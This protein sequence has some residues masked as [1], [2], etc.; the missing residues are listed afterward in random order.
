VVQDPEDVQEV[1]REIMPVCVSWS[2]F[3]KGL[4]VP[5]WPR[6]WTAGGGGRWYGIKEEAA[7]TK[8]NNKRVLESLGRV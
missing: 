2:S 1:R 8:I 3:G 5:D 4:N 6:G 7:R